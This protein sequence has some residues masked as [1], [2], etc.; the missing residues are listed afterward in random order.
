VPSVC[1]PK[2]KLDGENE[3]AGFP[4][5]P[6]QSMKKKLMHVS[7]TGLLILITLC[8]LGEFIAL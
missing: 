5:L 6:P 2:V 8:G 3:T 4:A 7:I 1:V